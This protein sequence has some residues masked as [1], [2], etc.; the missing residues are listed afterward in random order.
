MCR[1]IRFA[2]LLA[3]YIT[4][5]LRHYSTYSIYLGPFLTKK[6]EKKKMVRLG[7]RR[8]D[9]SAEKL[10]LDIWLDESAYMLC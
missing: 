9:E 2:I 10:L 7:V 6:N 8:P 3:H 5:L 4:V 1:R